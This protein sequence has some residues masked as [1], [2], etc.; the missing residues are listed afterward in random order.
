MQT[1]SVRHVTQYNYANPV[2]F[3]PHRLML[4]PRDSHD[5]RLVSAELLLTP[6]A[7]VRWLHDVLGRWV[8][9]DD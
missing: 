2:V 6:P 9:G 4:R 8:E 5:L 7:N 1:L 3:Q